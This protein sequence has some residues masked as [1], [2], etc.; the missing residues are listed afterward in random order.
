MAT[1]TQEEAHS[2]FDYRDGELFWKVRPLSY[3]KTEGRHVQWNERYGSQKAGSCVGRYVNIA[4]NK[5]RYQAHRIIF[6][7][8]YGY[9]PKVIDHINGQTQDNRIENLR[10]ATH[11]ENIR[12]SK[13]P[14]NNTSGLKNVVWHKQ[15]QK[16][17]VRIIVNKKSKSFGLYDD[18]ELADLVAREARNKYF[19]S[20]ARHS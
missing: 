4:I 19:G 2:L 12:N 14:K 5:I 18:I 13:I 16:W 17:G 1:L 9:F 6:L 15:R 20:F 3:F 10:A 11:A 8:H 7:M